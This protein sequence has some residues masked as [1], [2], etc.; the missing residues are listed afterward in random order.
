MMNRY[1]K[2]QPAHLVITALIPLLAL[3]ALTMGFSSC[4]DDDDNGGNV[5]IESVWSNWYNSDY[6]LSESR[7]LHACYPDK[8]IALKGSGFSGTTAVYCNGYQCPV[9]EMNISDN[10]LIFQIKY[11]TPPSDSITDENVKSTIRVVT[12]HGETTYKDF[13]IKN[14]A[15]V[16][17]ITSVSNTLPKAGQSIIVR[18]ANLENATAVYF[19]GESGDI[20]GKI[21]NVASGEVTVTVPDGTM[22]SGALRMVCLDENV[23][24]PNYMYGSAGNISISSADITL[25]SKAQILQGADAVAAATGL[26]ASAFNLPSIAIEIPETPAGML[27]KETNYNIDTKGRYFKLPLADALEAARAA[28]NIPQTTE[29]KN[30]A[31]QM[32]VY[33]PQAWASGSVVTRFRS[34]SNYTN[35]AANEYSAPWVVNQEDKGSLSFNGFETITI[36]LGN[37]ASLVTGNVTSIQAFIDGLKG[38]KTVIGFSNCYINKSGVNISSVITDF[39]IFIANLR[40]VNYVT[41]DNG[42]TE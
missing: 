5:N 23:Y 28:A 27:L 16:P 12:D 25:G 20:E 8:W 34:T 6:T 32:D 10:W 40:L 24:S 1:R 26:S 17:S 41:A 7:Q 31:L 30:L 36:P 4:S 18:G 22:K 13:V 33:M 3:I 29:L 21:T 9:K 14:N 35:T 2:E 37:H 15:A 19:P 38:D 39:Q 11:Q 42:Y